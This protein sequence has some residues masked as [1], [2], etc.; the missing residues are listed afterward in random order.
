M[1]VEIHYAKKQMGGALPVLQDIRNV[2]NF[3]F[4][5]RNFSFF[6][7][8]FDGISKSNFSAIPYF[9]EKEGFGVTA[10]IFFPLETPKL[11]SL[12]EDV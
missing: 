1:C 9:G 11:F 7:E 2:E 6:V 5:V 8:R 4:S 12:F 10:V 3:S